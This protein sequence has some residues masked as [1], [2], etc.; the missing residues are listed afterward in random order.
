MGACGNSGN[1]TEPHVHLQVTDSI[2]WTSA[3]GLPL[4]FRGP[5]GLTLPGESQIVSV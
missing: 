5:D 3:R 2:R 1:S 4:A